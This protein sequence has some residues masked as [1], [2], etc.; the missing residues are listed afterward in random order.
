MDLCP[1]HHI[2][3]NYLTL[4]VRTWD[5]M[6]ISEL[7]CIRI[8][9]YHTRD[10]QALLRQEKRTVIH[11]Y[12]LNRKLS[13]AFLLTSRLRAVVD[14]VKLSDLVVDCTRSL[15][16]VR[17]SNGCIAFNFASSSM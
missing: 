7:V 8:T 14:T 4:R 9:G 12:Y 1:L 11:R 10:A 2:Q 3:P 17:T 5:A 16:E 13:D 15:V 6:V